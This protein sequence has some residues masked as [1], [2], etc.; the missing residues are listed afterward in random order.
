MSENPKSPGISKLIRDAVALW[1][2]CLPQVA[3]ILIICTPPAAW[4]YGAIQR[5]GT[6][7]IKMILL[8]LFFQAFLVIGSACVIS[9]MEAKRSGKKEWLERALTRSLR[10]FGWD[11]LVGFQTLIRAFLPFLPPSARRPEEYQPEK[12][13]AAFWLDRLP[14]SAGILYG[15]SKMGLRGFVAVLSKR[16]MQDCMG[17]CRGR[18]LHIALLNL[19]ATLTQFAVLGVVS[20]TAKATGPGPSLGTSIVTFLVVGALQTLFS[21]YGL[22]LYQDCLAEFKRRFK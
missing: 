7:V 20:N 4:A 18:Y 22:L 15:I 5:A 6:D 21:A 14:I 3:L 19:L 9:V 17:I 16:G 1:V 11:L 10:L 8:L 13:S 12:G 2:K